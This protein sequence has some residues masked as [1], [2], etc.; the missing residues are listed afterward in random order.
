[1]RVTF[2]NSKGLRL[3][4]ILD[5]PKKENPPIIVFLHGLNGHKTYYKF[6]NE[7]AKELPKQGFA[8]LRF[9]F[10]SHGESDS[11]WINFTRASCTEDFKAAI[12]FLKTQKVDIKRLGV[13]TTSMGS[14]PFTLNSKPIKAAILHNAFILSK[15]LRRWIEGYEDE[16][17][18]RGHIE[19]KQAKTGRIIKW[20]I[21]LMEESIHSNYDSK[22]KEVKCPTLLIYGKDFEKETARE[23][24]ETFRCKKELQVIPNMSHTDTTPKQREEITKLSVGWFK[25]YL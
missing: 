18:E 16:I 21:S 14:I 23:T 20:G 7:L 13:F 22:I 12:K 24:F 1:M 2:K 25:K 9:D 15:S 19:Y 8:V 17:K 10:N 5:L 4:G 11:D 3:I 6:I